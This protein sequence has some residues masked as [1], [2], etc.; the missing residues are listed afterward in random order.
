MGHDRVEEKGRAKNTLREKEAGIP[1][2]NKRNRFIQQGEGKGKFF[3]GKY[4]AKA[5]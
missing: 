3:K 5:A 4:S 1:A 2:R